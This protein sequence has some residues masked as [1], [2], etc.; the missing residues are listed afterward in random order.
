MLIL[1]TGTST[2]LS[3]SR[4]LNFEPCTGGFSLIELLVVITII[5][6]FS[7]ATILSLDI[8]GNDRDLERE[9]FRFRSMTELLAQESV[10]EGRDYG[11]L[12]SEQ[13]YR[14]YIYDYRQ[15]IWLDPIG[16]SFLAAYR[17]QETVSIGL[18]LE[19]QEVALEPEVDQE[20]LVDPEPQVIIYSSG[21]LTPFKVV[22]SKEASD[23]SF[24]ITAEINGSLELS[25]HGY[26][27]P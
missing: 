27:G 6:I 8:L 5:G 4:R 18:F 10:M 20:L 17:L 15:L 16:D 2:N 12:F 25:E 13:G 14:F 24:V 19:D 26:D 7:G 22:F 3:A 23:G 1:G 21:Q 9:A 11:I